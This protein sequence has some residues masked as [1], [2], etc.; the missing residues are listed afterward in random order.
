M[1]GPKY[2]MHGFF[3]PGFPTLMRFQAHHDKILKKKLNGLQKHLMVNHMET[4]IY[5]LKWFLQ[6]FL[7]RIPFS[8]TIRVWDLYLLEGESIMIAMA[9]NI[10]K[11]HS[12]S[13]MKM[14]MD[15]LMDY[16]QKTLKKDFGYDDD[17][18]IET[19]LKESLEELRS[20]NLH[21]VGLPPDSEKPQKS[22]GVLENIQTE[23]EQSVVGKRLPVGAEETLFY[24]NT[25]QREE[26]NIKVLQQHIFQVS[27]DES[28][29][30]CLNEMEGPGEELDISSSSKT[31]TPTSENACSN[32]IPSSQTPS[33][34]QLHLMYLKWH[35][36]MKDESNDS[37][38]FQM[39]QRS[40]KE[41]Q[42][43]SVSNDKGSRIRK[44]CPTING[45]DEGS[46]TD[47]SNSPM[48]SS[49]SIQAELHPEES[50]SYHS[51]QHSCDDNQ[52]PKHDF[53]S[54]TSIPSTKPRYYFGE[55][56]DLE[57]IVNHSNAEEDRYRL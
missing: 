20:S 5:T 14:G 3:I 40:F 31:L 35:Q 9:Y 33:R 1:V 2:N 47:T 4:G 27:S 29:N 34:D 48:P 30:L 16:F 10:L 50:S 55:S 57:N 39:W 41:N 43:N 26:D 28:A 46:R 6:C 13:L 56:P 23:E 53:L 7:D 44:P 42:I 54:K 17:F 12:K 15:E 51:H 49:E 19:A 11:L 8:L 18:V 37:L 36:H 21:T 25:A 24:K 45:T 32:H 52:S 22:F 38:I